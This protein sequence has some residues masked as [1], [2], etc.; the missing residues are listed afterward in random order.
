MGHNAGYV[1]VK[2]NSIDPGVLLA[3][4]PMIDYPVLICASSKSSD[5]F[6]RRHPP[7]IGI[8]ARRVGAKQATAALSVEE[9]ARKYLRN[10]TSQM[11]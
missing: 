10:V 7:S 9:C 3:K 2:I 11:K 6:C 5:C 1:T 8:A 4:S